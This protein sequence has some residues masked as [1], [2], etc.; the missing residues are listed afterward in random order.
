MGSKGKHTLKKRKNK[1]GIIVFMQFIFI[2]CIIISAIYI[3]KWNKENKQTKEISL[4]IE[5]AVKV[6]ENNDSGEEKYDIDFNELKSINSDVVAW[7]KVKNTNIEYPIVKTSNNEYYLNHSLDKTVN[8][9][10]WPFMDYK[11]KLNGS[12]KN[13]VIYGHN[14]KDNSMFGT[15]ARTLNKEWYENKDNLEIIYITE[16][17]TSI[18]K[19]FSNY[20]ILNE[21]YYITT[22]F[23]QGE[24]LKF[25]KTLKN[26]SIHD[27]GVEVNESSQILT[28]STCANNNKYRVA[29]HAV[30]KEI[31]E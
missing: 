28:L 30:R 2:V 8:S 9:A 25:I 1:S 17:G 6:V 22:D 5:N 27:Y 3:L 31:E 16:E 14:R 18:Y 21:D 26:R 13:L 7:I 10:G 20:Q 23:T 11:E 19:V 12:D 4:K 15:L 29:L 24:F